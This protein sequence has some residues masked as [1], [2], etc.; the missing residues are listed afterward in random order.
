MNREYHRWYSPSLGRDMELLIHGH[1]GTP[2]LVFPSSMGRFFE[3]EDRGMIFAVHGQY[4]YGRAQAF[5]VDSVDS[6]SWYNK[7]AHPADRARR[8]AQYVNYVIHEVVPLIRRLNASPG[9][10]ITGCSFGGYHAMNLALRR[11]DIFI[12]CVSMSGAFDNKQFLHGYYDDNCYFNNPVDFL[13]GMN[14]PWYLDRYRGGNQY[15]LAAGDWDI[16]LGENQ[17]MDGI[18]HA[19]GIP[20]RLDIWGDRSEHDWPLWRRMAQA[21]F[22]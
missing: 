20:H 15:I 21:Y 13:P 5:C 1:A 17:R 8:H 14:D 4:E 22:G 18:M 10:V 16:C 19:K 9:I 11:P 3:Y 2:L 12:G 6:E 7:S